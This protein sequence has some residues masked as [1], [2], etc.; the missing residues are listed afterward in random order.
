MSYAPTFQSRK[1]KRKAPKPPNPL[2]LKVYLIFAL[3]VVVMLVCLMMSLVVPEVNVPQPDTVTGY[4][5]QQSRM[6]SVFQRANAQA[7][8]SALSYKKELHNGEWMVTGTGY[9]NVDVRLSAF[10]M[11]A[12]HWQE[13]EEVVLE[14]YPQLRP[15]EFPENIDMEMFALSVM[16]C[17]LSETGS[18]GG[19]DTPEYGGNRSGVMAEWQTMTDQE[20]INALLDP[21][22]MLSRWS[23][24]Y[25]YY[26]NATW[27]GWGYGLYQ[28]T[29]GRREVLAHLWQESGYDLSQIDGQMI[30]VC[31]EAMGSGGIGGGTSWRGQYAKVFSQMTPDYFPQGIY[32]DNYKYGVAI[33]WA[34]CVYGW[35]SID[36]AK[37][38]AGRMSDR[39][40]NL[41]SSGYAVNG[42]TWYEIYTTFADLGVEGVTALL[43]S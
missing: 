37:A 30:M 12:Y 31:A 4:N 14:I 25:A 24:S 42:H 20:K 34:D 9:D 3:I 10:N 11:L 1:R 7:A 38:S 23:T 16:G 8:D 18:T 39:N 19:V 2:M 13:L 17:S 33:F 5:M 43:A 36:Y 21:Y 32:G 40:D 27:G 22:W 15:I 35:G 29:A 28:W 41:S 6:L 26:N